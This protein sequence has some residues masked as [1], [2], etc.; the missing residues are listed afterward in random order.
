MYSS[1]AHRSFHVHD[2]QL[3]PESFQ[4]PVCESLRVKKA[5][6]VQ[7]NPDVFFN[8]CIDCHALFSSRMPVTSVLDSLYANYDY[9]ISYERL[10]NHI[11]QYTLVDD[12]RVLDFGGGKSTSTLDHVIVDYGGKIAGEYDLVI[13]SGVLEHVTDPR[14]TIN[15]LF[16][17]LKPDGFFYARTPC[18]ARL[19]K[20]IPVLDTGFPYH[21]YDFSREFWNKVPE[22][23]DLECDI[24]VSRPSLIE[25][26]LLKNPARTVVSYLL[27]KIGLTAGWEIILKQR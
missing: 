8:K 12:C 9:C 22:T 17:V 5:F 24:V 26:E 13:A 23:C 25:T 18:I 20:I 2:E 15:E 3:L 16:S 27:K 6:R 10:L 19:K 4:C 21:L 7:Q 1:L 14:S 11:K